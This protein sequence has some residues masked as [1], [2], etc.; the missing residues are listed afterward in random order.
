MTAL[1]YS[2][3]SLAQNRC[4]LIPQNH[5]EFHT[6]IESNPFWVLNNDNDNTV[7]YL[8]CPFSLI[9]VIAI[10]FRAYYDTNNQF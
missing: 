2:H 1:S 7:A 10:H 3:S 4:S 9:F 6:W 5:I 8:H